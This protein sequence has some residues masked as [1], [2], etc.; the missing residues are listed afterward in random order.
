MVN[1]LLINVVLNEF[2]GGNA[3]EFI[4]FF[5]FIWSAIPKNW[6]VFLSI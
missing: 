2:K 3:L 4:G 6:H 5:N 1:N